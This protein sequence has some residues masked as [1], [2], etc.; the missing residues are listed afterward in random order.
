LTGLESIAESSLKTSDILDYIKKQIA[1]SEPSKDWRTEVKEDPATGESQQGFGE[2]LKTYLEKDLSDRLNV[3]CSNVGI[4]TKLE[5]GKSKQDS[6]IEKEK[7][8]A[9]RW[10]RQDIH[11]RLIREFIRQMVVQYEYRTGEGGE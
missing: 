1:R 2:S 5:K 7:L 4:V 10:K 6:E 11:L 9:H 8:K 3:V